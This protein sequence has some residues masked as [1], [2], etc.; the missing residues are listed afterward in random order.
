M[1]MEFSRKVSKNPQMA[2]FVKIPLVRAKLF[3]A[4]RQTDR[5]NEVNNRFS[6]FCEST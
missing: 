2:N 1:T 6:Q 5:Y 3:N 4:D